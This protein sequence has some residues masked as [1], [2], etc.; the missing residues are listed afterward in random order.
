MPRIDFYVDFVR[1]FIFTQV[2]EFQNSSKSEMIFV[3]L[4]EFF[5]FFG[6]FYLAIS[7]E[8]WTLL[9]GIIEE[10][11]EFL[12]RIEKTQLAFLNENVDYITMFSNLR[13]M[14]E[15]I[16][17]YK[18][19][20]KKSFKSNDIFSEIFQN[21]G[22]SDYE[23]NF[24][25]SNLEETDFKGFLFKMVIKYLSAAYFQKNLKKGIYKVFKI[26]KEDFVFEHNAFNIQ[27]ILL[28]INEY[29]QKLYNAL[30][31]L[32]NKFAPGEIH[33]LL[34]NIRRIIAVFSVISCFF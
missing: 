2:Q 4:Y 23:Q 31:S 15:K 12:K 20:N 10:V 14:T 1:L 3:S 27:N 7:L 9:G 28:F 26:E 24:N 11:L 22:D 33:N 32:F 18:Q 6:L 34:E 30:K 25:C 19:K 16:S 5:V 13:L 21:P 17:N 8:S 29:E